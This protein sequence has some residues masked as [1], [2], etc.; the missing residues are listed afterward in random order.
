MT[1][2]IYFIYCVHDRIWFLKRTFS[3]N[4]RT[5]GF[6]LFYKP[7]ARHEQHKWNTSNMGRTWGRDKFNTCE[8][9]VTQVWHNDDASATQTTRVRHECWRN[10]MIA[11]RVKNFDFD[12]DTCENNFSHPFI[13]YMTNERFKKTIL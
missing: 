5:L 11:T 10:N 13:Y 4:Y 12:N 9:W 2:S 3:S 7:S 6:S 8:T 1:L